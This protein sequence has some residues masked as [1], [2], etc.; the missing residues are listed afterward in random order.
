MIH[1]KDVV[2]RST[3]DNEKYLRTNSS[4]SCFQPRVVWRQAC[5]EPDEGMALLL[6]IPV[7]FDVVWGRNNYKK[8][9]AL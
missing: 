6:M 3:K 5:P 7:L 8:E 2:G 1:G 4:R 9:E